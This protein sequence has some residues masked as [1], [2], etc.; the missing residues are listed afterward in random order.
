MNT[1]INLAPNGVLYLTFDKLT[2]AGVKHGFSTRIGGV[3]SGIYKSMNLSFHRGDDYENVMENHRRFAEAIGYNHLD[4]V[5][6]DQI[7]ETHIERVGI[8]D[9]GHG[10]KGEKGMPGADGLVTDEPGVPIMTFYADCVPLFFYD[11]VNKVIAT[12]HSGWRG[13]IAGIG[14][15]MVEYMCK[16]MGCNRDDII[17]VIGPSICM[18]CYEVSEDVALQFEKEFPQSIH[19]ELLHSKGNGK[20]LLNLWKANEHIL[21]S[22]GI[23]S[24]NLDIPEICTCHNPELM[25]SHRQTMGNR[26]NMAGVIVL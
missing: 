4:T 7:H 6:S 9:R 25:I 2:K 8:K 1:T 16:E 19:D 5:F 23:K 17:A 18:N 22:A 11:P 3:S 26:G 12:A 14:G 20:Y 10:M 24:D 13:T 21:L 15:K